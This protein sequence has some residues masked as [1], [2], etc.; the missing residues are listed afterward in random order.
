[1]VVVMVVVGVVL[2]ELVV[3]VIVLL[4]VFFL[5]IS[6]VY[7][8]SVYLKQCCNM[9]IDKKEINKKSNKIF[10]V[11]CTKSSFEAVLLE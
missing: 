8:G 11:A 2:V 7:K 1:M 3:V 9:T 5:F 4:V 6:Y 10:W